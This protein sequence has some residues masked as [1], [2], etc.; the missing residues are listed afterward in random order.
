MRS[1]EDVYCS[2]GCTLKNGKPAR[3]QA[4]GAR[5]RHKHMVPS[6]SG[7][8]QPKELVENDNQHQEIQVES[9]LEFSPDQQFGEEDSRSSNS[10]VG[11]A[12]T[13]SVASIVASLLRPQDQSLVILLPWFKVV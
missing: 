12:R 10:E 9:S 2:L 8:Q 13:T 3:H 5:C 1:G 7:E 6:T 4:Y 11:D